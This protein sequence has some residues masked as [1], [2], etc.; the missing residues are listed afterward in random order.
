M[1]A[2]EASAFN[3]VEAHGHHNGVNAT[4]ITRGRESAD[5]SPHSRWLQFRGASTDR[6]NET[7]RVGLT[8]QKFARS[9]RHLSVIARLFPPAKPCR[10]SA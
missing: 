9:D 3:S 8:K 6:A 5:D 7:D 1:A 4:R 2:R 10:V